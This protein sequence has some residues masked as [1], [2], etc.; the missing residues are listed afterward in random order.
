VPVNNQLRG[1]TLNLGA[2][3][4][5]GSRILVGRIAG[6]AGE[7]R[8]TADPSPETAQQAMSQWL[9]AIA[10]SWLYRWLYH[11]TGDGPFDS[12]SGRCGG[13]R[14]ASDCGAMGESSGRDQ[15]GHRGYDPGL[16]GPVGRGEKAAS[17]ES[18]TWSTLGRIAGC[19]RSW[20]AR[21]R[22]PAFSGR[23]RR[24]E[25]GTPTPAA[26]L[27]PLYRFGG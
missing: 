16:H 25:S 27:T 10:E 6:P 24:A 17:A 3:E 14:L 11:S 4:K 22:R 9:T 8:R 7:R 21:Q 1:G 26:A 12:F 18:W 20:R 15:G 19:E 23:D 13:R 2:I 5:R